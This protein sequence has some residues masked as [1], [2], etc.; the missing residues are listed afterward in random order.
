[1]RVEVRDIR[2]FIWSV[3]ERRW[4]L[5]Q[6]ALGVVGAHYFDDFR[7]NA[8]VP[9]DPRTEADGGTSVSMIPG[10]NFHFWPDTGRAGVSP[11]DV[12]AVVTIYSARLIGAAA[13]DAK[14]IASAGGD[15]WRAPGALFDG[16]A[17]G[18][19]N[20]GIGQGRFVELSSIW[21]TVAFYTG[22]P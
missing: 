3:S 1:V 12:G 17:I 14:Y 20:D 5:V 19:H 22:G 7:S 2:S 10:Y 18:A 21:T 13:A 6:E 11:G 8:S 15:W 4:A 16:G 9:A